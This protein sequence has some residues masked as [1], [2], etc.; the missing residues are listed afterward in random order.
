MSVQAGLTVSSRKAMH[1]K[2]A[3]NEGQGLKSNA[4]LLIIFSE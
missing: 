2:Y 3:S 1:M 4:S